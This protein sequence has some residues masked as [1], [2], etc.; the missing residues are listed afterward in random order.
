MICIIFATFPNQGIGN[1]MSCLTKIDPMHKQHAHLI[2][3]L[4]ACASACYHCATACLDEPD[5]NVMKACI[6]LDLDC[7][8]ICQTA[9]A[10]VCRGSD[11]AR[12]V[13]KECEEIC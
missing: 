12:H 13:L 9:I 8:Q 5:V 10:F 3:T 2:E 6:R 1:F 7:A 11:H 4:S